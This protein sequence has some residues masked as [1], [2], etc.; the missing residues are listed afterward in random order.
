[1]Q[2]QSLFIWSRR[3]FTS[4][5]PFPLNHTWVTSYPNPGP[6][7]GFAKPFPADAHYWFCW[8][9]LHSGGDGFQQPAPYKVWRGP[10]PANL[11]LA[12][13]ICQA[14][15]PTNPTNKAWPKAGIEGKYGHNGVC[16][17]V[18]NRVLWSAGLQPNGDA[19]TVEGVN[20]WKLSWDIYGAYGYRDDFSNWEEVLRRC[21]GLGGDGVDLIQRMNARRPRLQSLKAQ[22]TISKIRNRML[23]GKE[24]LDGR[25]D[26]G[27]MTARQHADAVNELMRHYLLEASTLL[28]RSDFMEYFQ[29]DFEAGVTPTLIDPDIA[30]LYENLERE[31]QA[32]AASAT[33]SA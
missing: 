4:V 27:L 21:D 11:R 32:G 12:L 20:G 8:G 23:D 15:T 29:V 1:M 9:S 16:H 14:N 33:A 30:E 26:L 5:N 28:A 22:E 17:Q 6:P 7:D 24:K 13:C 31:V 19:L 18:A 3:A 2:E 10:A 25:H